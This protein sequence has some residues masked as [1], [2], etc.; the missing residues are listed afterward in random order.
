MAE[1]NSSAVNGGV[2]RNLEESKWKTLTCPFINPTIRN[3]NSGP[4]IKSKVNTAQGTSYKNTISKLGIALTI[5][6]FPTPA[7]I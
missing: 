6:A 4:T 2:N 3:D 5:T 1:V 7:V